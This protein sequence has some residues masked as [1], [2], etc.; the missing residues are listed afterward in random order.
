[1][2]NRILLPVVAALTALAPGAASA[3]SVITDCD[4]RRADHDVEIRVEATETFGEP[5]RIRT[6]PGFIR[7]WFPATQATR[8][9]PRAEVDGIRFVRVRSGIDDMAVVIIR[10]DSMRRLDESDVTIER[11]GGV[12]R[13]RLDGS[14]LGFAQRVPAPR[15]DEPSAAEVEE[16]E[17]EASGDEAPSAEAEAPAAEA[18][19]TPPGRPLFG[20]TSAAAAG[21]IPDE[22][23]S[24]LTMLVALL[25]LLGVAYL[26]VAVWRSRRGRGGD[27]AR[28][29]IRVVGQRRVG[30]RHQIMVVRALGQDHLLS[31]CAG[32]TSLIA[33]V[34]SPLS[35][36][37]GDG[38]GVAEDA[39]PFLRLS[40]E[41]GVGNDTTRAART[42]TE[43][44]PRFGA[45][46][47][48]AAQRNVTDH[49]TL[50]APPPS[51]AVAG[52][53]RLREKLGR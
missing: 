48:R 49:V 43:D 21:P 22:G 45:E 12:A 39:T 36:D 40:S 37:L 13:I 32:Q 26:A 14:A 6:S 16:T 15:E 46:L 30:A 10:L 4:M 31:V 29:D 38:G 23:S 9:E 7:V 52:L 25:A 20:D 47:L 44:R 42:A 17:P 53:L 1:M 8:L 2:N 24:P 11:E 19:A 5:A 50:S 33:S 18:A 27:R 35:E 3:N 41:P 51:D 28:P 34:P